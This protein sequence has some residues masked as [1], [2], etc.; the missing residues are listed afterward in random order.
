MIKHSKL[1]DQELEFKLQ[2]KFDQL[3]IKVAEDQG[4]NTS[5][6]QY[7]M[8]GGGIPAQL[9]QML[10]QGKSEAADINSIISRQLP[11]S[12]KLNI[13]FTKLAKIADSKGRKSLANFLIKQ[14][15]SIVKKIPF[16][17]EAKQFEEAL[18][19][20]IEGGDPNIINKVFTEILN[21]FMGNIKA[22]IQTASQIPE[23]LRHLRN[24]AKSR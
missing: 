17:L 9:Q 14:E 7:N 3:K 4:I 22:P 16:L 8:S 24:Y 12:I 15:K 10:L 21:K 1:S 20:A 5:I 19:F 11:S 13:D 18:K 2:E 6:L 23:G